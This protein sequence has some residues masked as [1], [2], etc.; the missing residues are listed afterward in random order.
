MLQC[1]RAFLVVQEVLFYWTVA[2]LCNPFR[3]V[4]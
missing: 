4:S 2:H 1:S 3:W